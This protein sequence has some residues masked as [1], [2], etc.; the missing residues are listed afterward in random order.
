MRMHNQTIFKSHMKS[1]RVL[2]REDAHYSKYFDRQVAYR[3]LLSLKDGNKIESSAYQHFRGETPVAL[4]IDIST[5]VGCPM[6]CKFCASSSIS[7]SRSLS[8]QEIAEQVL[9][10][11]N[12]YD[13]PRFPKI[14]CSYQG[15][16]EPSL[17]AE[18]ILESSSFLLG[19][20][21]RIRISIATIGARLDAFELWRKSGIQI[22]NLQISSS[23]TT[24]EQIN[25]LMPRTTSIEEIIYEAELCAQNPNFEQVKYN[26]I[27]ISGF[28]DSPADVKRLISLFSG[29]SIIVK[30]SALNSTISSKRNKH[31]PGT[32]E[33]A[34]E[35]CYELKSNGIN[36]FI[37]GSFDGTNV[38]CGQLIFTDK[39]EEQK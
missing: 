35:I 17:I 33:R 29:T 15:I 10:L 8:L 25:N 9:M 34:Q 28:N 16:G 37:F 36:S 7:F 12:Q 2:R 18:R 3:H 30:I 38:G 32:L 19:L 11:V 22:A 4:A 23:G 24:D 6:K 13:T 14:M 27:L 26:Y 1:S 21:S 5:M 31:I 39:Q 20:D